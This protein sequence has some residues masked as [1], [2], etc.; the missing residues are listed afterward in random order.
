[1][2]SGPMLSEFVASQ[3]SSLGIRDLE[4]LLGGMVLHRGANN[5]AGEN[6][7]CSRVL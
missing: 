1:M 7:M 3:E 6:S 5:D 4:L 2:H